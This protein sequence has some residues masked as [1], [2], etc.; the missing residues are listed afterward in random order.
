MKTMKR[1]AYIIGILIAWGAMTAGVRAEDKPAV[2]LISS[3]K[4]GPYQAALQALEKELR[5]QHPS[6]QITSYYLDETTPQDVYARLQDKAPTLICS[7]GTSATKLA[8]KI[9]GVNTVYTLIFET[10]EFNPQYMTG[11]TL[12]VGAEEKITLIK[13]I[14]P[15]VRKIGLLYSARSQARF[16]EINDTARRQGLEIVARKVDNEKD[17]PQALKEV[18]EQSDCFLMVADAQLFFPK[19]V[20]HLLRESIKNQVPVMGLSNVYTRAGA[21]FSLDVDFEQVG[22]QTGEMAARVLR[23]ESP[24]SLPVA[25]PKKTYFSLNLSTAKRLGIELASDLIKRAGEVFGR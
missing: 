16:K 9:S 6:V 11:V 2:A 20:E 17:F 24:A 13:T 18:L 3:A 10:D 1:L 25:L 4:I 19:S 7:L 22:R 5:S 15:S 14:L 21:L 23:K 8:A 12:D